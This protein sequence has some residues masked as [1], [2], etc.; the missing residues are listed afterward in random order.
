MTFPTALA[1]FERELEGVPSIR[2]ATLA[3]S[4]FPARDS[5]HGSDMRHPAPRLVPP[6]YKRKDPPRQ[7]EGCC[8]EEFKYPADA[9]IVVER[10]GKPSEFPVTWRFGFA[11]EAHARFALIGTRS[12]DAGRYECK[13]NCCEFRQEMQ[14]WVELDTDQST[15]RAIVKGFKDDYMRITDP[16]EDEQARKQIE[17]YQKSAYSFPQKGPPGEKM[18][19]DAAVLVP[20]KDRTIAFVPRQDIEWAYGADADAVLAGKKIFTYGDRASQDNFGNDAYTGGL[21]GGDRMNGCEYY[22]LDL[23]KEDWLLGVTGKITWR[24]AG[25]IL[26]RNGCLGDT[27][28]EEFSVTFG[29]SWVQRGERPWMMW[30]KLDCKLTGSIKGLAGSFLRSNRLDT[31]A[32]AVDVGED[33]PDARPTLTAEDKRKFKDQLKLLSR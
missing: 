5:W 32:Q 30:P 17:N 15:V 33:L 14:R 7:R 20:T 16:K 28:R 27:R 25:S 12:A 4:S 23:P 21:F 18:G 3:V 8:V 11:F 29:V 13:C 31:G 26:P 2:H 6:L 10:A 24:F 9:A 19:V 1:A 22:M